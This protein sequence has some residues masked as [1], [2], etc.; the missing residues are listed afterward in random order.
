MEWHFW[1]FG[2][3][4]GPHDGAGAGLKH[5]I[6]QEQLKLKFPKFPK[7]T[8]CSCVQHN[9]GKDMLPV[10]ELEGRSIEPFGRL[11]QLSLIAKS[12]YSLI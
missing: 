7:Y 10:K 5:R 2:H 1:G 9:N 12:L 4:K 3:E 8:W 11:E 6:R